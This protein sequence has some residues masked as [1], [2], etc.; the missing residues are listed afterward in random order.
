MDSDHV[1]D[2]IL[3]ETDPAVVVEMFREMFKRNPMADEQAGYL[4]QAMQ[5][6]CLINSIDAIFDLFIEKKFMRIG[7]T[8]FIDGWDQNWTT[9][10]HITSRY[11]ADDELIQSLRQSIYKMLRHL[12]DDNLDPIY[13]VTLLGDFKVSMEGTG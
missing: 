8:Y 13:Y 10:R 11:Y 4:F 12:G 3:S 1:S 5:N 9:M 6:P 7:L 2:I